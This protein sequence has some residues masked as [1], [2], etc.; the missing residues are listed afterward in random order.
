M[1]KLF[2]RK[3][4][5]AAFQQ[6][7]E[8]L[9]APVTVYLLGGGAMA[10]RGQKPGTKDLDLLL[11]NNFQLPQLHKA[12]GRAKF[13]P[14]IKLGRTYE[15]MQVSGG[16]WDNSDGFRIDLFVEKVVD[17]LSL[18]PPMKQRS[19]PLGTFGN[20]QVNSVSN[21]DIVLF[22]S[23]TGRP[24]DTADMAAIVR[25]T[26][27]DWNVMLTECALQSKTRPWHGHM[28]EALRDLKER[29]GIDA[30]ITRKLES[31][32]KDNILTDAYRMKLE[33][34][35]A[36]EQIVDELVGMGFSKR[37]VM[38]MIKAIGN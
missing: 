3:Y 9:Q 37:K 20:L 5:D 35:L 28:L 2:D 34:G 6:I 30:P 36:P 32:N 18:T 10:F 17:K 11:E 15:D 12:L 8:S 24:D 38:R 4:L 33:K 29:F 23:V 1:K 22:K 31:L 13:S 27:F 7:G 16:V 14:V 21:E 19:T 25:Q 26:P